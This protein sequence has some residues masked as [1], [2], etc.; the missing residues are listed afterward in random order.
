M[1]RNFVSGFQIIDFNVETGGNNN[2]SDN[3]E[4]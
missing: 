4:Y 1:N 3:N 2:N